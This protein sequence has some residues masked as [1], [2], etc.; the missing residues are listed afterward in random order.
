MSQGSKK[1]ISAKEKCFW[2]VMS[3]YGINSKEDLKNWEYAGGDGISTSYNNKDILV[4][5][6]ERKYSYQ[7]GITPYIMTKIRK[8][9]CPCGSVIKNN[10]YIQNKKDPSKIIVVGNIC[11]KKYMNKFRHCSECG[12]VHKNTKN[13]I[14]N[15]C[16]INKSNP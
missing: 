6:G 5:S 14:C 12:S 1:N 16:R 8:E 11:I 9:N 3:S 15:G 13:N 10:M 7:R 4:L 2:K